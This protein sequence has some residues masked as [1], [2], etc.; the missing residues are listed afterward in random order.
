MSTALAITLVVGVPPIVIEGIALYMQIR[1]KRAQG[2][3]L[4]HTMLRYKLTFFSRGTSHSDAPSLVRLS[5]EVEDFRQQVNVG[6]QGPVKQMCF[7]NQG[8]R[9]ERGHLSVHK[10]EECY[11]P[12][13]EESDPR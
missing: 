1:R 9:N 5:L 4:S 13:R 7:G 3:S 11:E 10:R 12:L 2:P 6:L 8:E